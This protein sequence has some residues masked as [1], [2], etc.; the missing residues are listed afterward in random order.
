MKRLKNK[1][2]SLLQKF[3][4]QPTE[5]E[6]IPG[7]LELSTKLSALENRLLNYYS[8]RWDAFD[9]IA[10]YLVGAEIPGDYWEFG[11]YAGATF[12]YAYK[13]MGSL[14]KNMRFI[15]LD[16]FQGLPSIQ[17]IDFQA[18]QVEQHPKGRQGSVLFQDVAGKPR[19]KERDEYQNNQTKKDLVGRYSTRIMCIGGV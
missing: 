19:Q 11:V 15:G 13:V 6:I 5:P 4:F 3:I 1:Y 18:V 12:S 8:N 17:G 14:F 2:K 9:N 7:F 16:S 10:D